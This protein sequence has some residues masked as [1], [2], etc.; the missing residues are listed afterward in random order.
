MFNLKLKWV[1]D[2]ETYIVM[3]GSRICI[4]PGEEKQWIFICMPLIIKGRVRARSRHIWRRDFGSFNCS[5]PFPSLYPFSYT[6]QRVLRW[7]LFE[8]TCITKINL[9]IGINK[10][11]P[12]TG[13]YLSKYKYLQWIKA[14]TVSYCDESGWSFEVIRIRHRILVGKPA[15][16]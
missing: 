1:Y 9:L 3:R 6:S 2:K 10:E 16:E 5:I 14:P 8:C 11:P 13:S 12:C 7:L 15:Q 4:Y